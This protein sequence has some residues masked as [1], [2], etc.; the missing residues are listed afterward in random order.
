MRGM[1][2][3]VGEMNASGVDPTP[4]YRRFPQAC[5]EGV[6]SFQFSVFSKKWLASCSPLPLL[7]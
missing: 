5:G 3:T 6:F 1:S 2:F 4:R 7:D